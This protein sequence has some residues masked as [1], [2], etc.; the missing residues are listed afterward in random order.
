MAKAPL[1]QVATLGIDIGKNSFHL[2]GLD[3][4]GTIVFARSSPADRLSSAW[5]TCPPA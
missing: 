5:P 4:R 2:I 1:H 3:A